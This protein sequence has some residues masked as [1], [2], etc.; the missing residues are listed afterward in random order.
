MPSEINH[1]FLTN[2]FENE[3]AEISEDKNTDVIVEMHSGKKY[4]ASFFTFAG[5]QE[6]RSKHLQSGAFLHG[7]YFWAKNMLLID[8]CSQ[9]EIQLVIKDLIEEGDFHTVFRQI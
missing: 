1:V 7:K 8:Q 6:L 2:T 9:S 5:I 4:I 3:D